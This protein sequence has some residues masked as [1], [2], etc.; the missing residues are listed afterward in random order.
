MGRTER[1]FSSG[2]YGINRRF[3]SMGAAGWRRLNVEYAK[4]FGVEVPGGK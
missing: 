1:S 4:Q 2:S 3:V